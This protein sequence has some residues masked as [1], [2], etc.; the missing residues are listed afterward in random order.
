MQGDVGR[1]G[2]MQRRRRALSQMAS[3]VRALLSALNEVMKM[4]FIGGRGPARYG[5]DM[6]RYGGDIG[7]MVVPVQMLA[8]YLQWV[9][10][11]YMY[12]SSVS[13]K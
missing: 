11:G 9:V 12:S 13:S 7:E 5:G 10:G 2:E 6:G 1:C 4:L 8:M 3:W